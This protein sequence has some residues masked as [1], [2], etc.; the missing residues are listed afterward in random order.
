MKTRRGSILLVVFGIVVLTALA[1]ASVLRQSTS[2]GWTA[3]ANA[4]RTQSRLAAWSGLEVVMSELASQRSRLLAGGTPE[5]TAR[6]VIENRESGN[7]VARLLPLGRSTVISECGKIDVNRAHVDWLTRH[8]DLTPELVA[9][10]DAAR[11]Q[12]QLGSAEELS[13]L[14]VDSAHLE[15]PLDAAD[16]QQPAAAL[17][18]SLGVFAMDTT[19]D[20]IGAPVCLCEPLSDASCRA[21][22]DIAGIDLCAVLKARIEAGPP[23]ASRSEFARVAL[24]AAVEPRRLGELLSRVTFSKSRLL[25]GLVDL[26]S[27]PAATLACLP[28]LDAGLAQRVLE[29]RER[30]SEEDRVNPLWPVIAE[31]VEMDRY[32]PLLDHV[33]VRSLVWRVRVEAGVEQASGGGTEDAPS[34]LRDRCVLEAVID[35]STNRPRV[36]YLRDVTLLAVAARLNDMR[37]AEPMPEGESEPAAS[38]AAPSEAGEPAATPTVPRSGRVSRWSVPK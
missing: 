17:G 26:N 1:A 22:N 3:A 18:S 25:P 5:L 11:C 2:T 9:R 20:P 27:A 32:L 37:P 38:I 30:L 19:D 16:D 4:R 7:I 10:I 34:P 21:I 36:A 15:W 28:G 8:P 31:I 6:T 29:A 14:G 33:G 35:L 13:R 12:V 23:I 24:G